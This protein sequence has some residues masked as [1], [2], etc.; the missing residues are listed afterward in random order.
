MKSYDE[1]IKFNETQNRF[2]KLVQDASIGWDGQ[3]PIRKIETIMQT[4]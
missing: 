2:L 4:L 3:D 1:L